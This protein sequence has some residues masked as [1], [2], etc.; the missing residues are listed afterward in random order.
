ML[1]TIKDYQSFLKIWLLIILK[2]AI[3]F[4]ESFIHYIQNISPESFP[5]PLS[6]HLSVEKFSY[7]EKFLSY[8]IIPVCDIREQTANIPKA[9]GPLLRMI[10]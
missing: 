10:Y 3:I 9:G 1:L 6:H 5:Y 4:M 7:F 8:Y 2:F